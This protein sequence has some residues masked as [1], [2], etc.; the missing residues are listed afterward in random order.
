MVRAIDAQQVIIQSPSAE[1]VQQIQQQNPD[2]QQR[3]FVLQQAEHDRIMKES[4]KQ[5]DESEKTA[6]KEKEERKDGHK[7]KDG[8]HHNEPPELLVE[9]E[10]AGT[11]D[12]EGGHIHIKV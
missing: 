12:D 5:S 1:R 4:V 10:S 11:T 2:L 9:E 8:R 7:G 6:I 3:Y